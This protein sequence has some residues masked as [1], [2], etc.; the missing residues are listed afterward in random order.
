MPIHKLIEL[1]DG[2]IIR[3]KKG[4]DNEGGR[5]LGWRIENVK[6]KT[7]SSYESALRQ[8]RAIKATQ[9]RRRRVVPTRGH[10]SIDI[11]QYN[12]V[13]V[14][15]K[16]HKV[17]K[18]T[19]NIKVTART[20]ILPQHQMDIFTPL[21]EDRFREISRGQPEGR[22]RPEEIRPYLTF[23]TKVVP[24]PAIPG[25]LGPEEMEQL[26]FTRPSLIDYLRW[27]RDL[28][29]YVV[30]N[31]LVHPDQSV[32]MI[33]G[34]DA[35][36]AAQL[37]EYGVYT[38]ADYERAV[39]QFIQENPDALTIAEARKQGM[40]DRKIR[41][42]KMWKELGPKEQALIWED[43]D[44]VSKLDPESLPEGF[45]SRRT[46]VLVT[47]AFIKQRMAEEAEAERPK[48]A[49]GR[50]KKEVTL[51]DLKE[52]KLKIL[53]NKKLSK[54]QRDRQAGR[55]SREISRR[56][57]TSRLE[58]QIKNITD[59]EKKTG[60]LSESD[61]FVLATGDLTSTSRRAI[62]KSKKEH[63][64][65]GSVTLGNITYQPRDLPK[66]H[67]NKTVVED[68]LNN[69]ARNIDTYIFIDKEPNRDFV[70]SGRKARLYDPIYRENEDNFFLKNK[71]ISFVGTKFKGGKSGER[72][73]G[74]TY[75]AK[76]DIN[77]VLAA[78]EERNIP[79]PSA[80][81]IGEDKATKSLPYLAMA[82]QGQ[83]LIFITHKGYFSVKPTKIITDD[84]RKRPPRRR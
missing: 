5:L 57:H 49:G 61:R 29:D 45:A 69:T 51:K 59:V 39:K 58:K 66:K 54:G 7:H 9:S 46:E 42:L 12:R 25:N 48:G 3:R 17:T 40:A 2:R 14:R 78:I 36:T 70:L 13:S 24:P 16:P 82:G 74:R 4:T 84:P 6:G 83:P 28:G 63:T 62:N 60:H 10:R 43:L 32:Q 68:V 1:S 27:D 33:K 34:V 44:E 76:K 23:R 47:E 64:T 31:R 35:E 55:I 50:P 26:G 56:Q 80:T 11:S 18:H 30:D 21:S 71:Q 72:M 77:T 8:Q 41:I 67:V 65:D 75:Y 81:H 37:N 15:G 53:T 22:M 52:K 38:V 79:Y 19:R 20:V 73:G